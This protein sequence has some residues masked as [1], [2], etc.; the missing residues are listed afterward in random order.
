MV[1]PGDFAVRGGII[2][3][4]PPGAD[5]PVRLD[6]FGDT[7]ESIRSF[8]PQSQRTTGTLKRFTLNPA[9]E[10]L[11][12]AGSHRPLPQGLCRGLRRHRHFRSAL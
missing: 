8:D 2:D 10:V 11:L 9:N 1:D 7:L 3:I 4:F 6:F 12:N 5:A